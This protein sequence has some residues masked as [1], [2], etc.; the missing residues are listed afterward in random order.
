MI[1]EKDLQSLKEQ[2]E[3]EAGELDV[4][5]SRH[6]KAP[7]F[8]DDVEGED[9]AEEA[10]EAEE[11]GNDLGITTSLKGRLADIELALD[12][13]NRNEYGKCES[14]GEEISL[15]LLKVNPESRMCKECKLKK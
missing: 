15:D 7:D 12:K 10:D 13:M 8:G 2:L 11:T 9:M 6:S 5:V 3:K 4:E 1:K 14:C